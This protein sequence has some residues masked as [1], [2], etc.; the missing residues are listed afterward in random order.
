MKEYT[1]EE[2]KLMVKNFNSI[3]SFR[4]KIDAIRANKDILTLAAD[5]NWWGVKVTDELIQETLEEEEIDFEIEKE[6]GH[7]EMYDLVYLLGIGITDI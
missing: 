1:L 6:W 4:G 3:K 5:G 2:C 7:N